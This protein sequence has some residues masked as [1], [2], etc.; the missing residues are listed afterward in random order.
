MK[1]YI[2][3]IVYILFIFWE[4]LL[5]WRYLKMIKTKKYEPRIKSDHKEEPLQIQYTPDEIAHMLSIKRKL[6]FGK[7]GKSEFCSSSYAICQ[8]KLR[9]KD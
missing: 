5:L 9:T 6:F 2:G 1:P 8:R 3:V 4:I 7:H